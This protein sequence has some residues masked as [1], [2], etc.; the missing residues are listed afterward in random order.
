[1]AAPPKIA[2]DT[3]N[4]V[5]FVEFQFWILLCFAMDKPQKNRKIAHK[6]QRSTAG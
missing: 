4:Y 3:D 1:M 5:I 2:K 6:Y